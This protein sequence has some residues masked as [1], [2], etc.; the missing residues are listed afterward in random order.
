[1]TLASKMKEKIWRFLEST[2]SN[3]SFIA[4]S[5]NRSFI[6]GSKISKGIFDHRESIAGILRSLFDSQP[7]IF[8]CCHFIFYCFY[9]KLRPWCKRLSNSFERIKKYRKDFWSLINWNQCYLVS[10]HPKCFT[11]IVF[12][13]L[14]TFS[15]SLLKLIFFDI[16][17]NKH[18]PIIEWLKK[19]RSA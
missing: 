3:V 10:Y 6:S 12:V 7:L 9:N 14:K 2:E 11:R 19:K 15:E 16:H 8:N 5:G 18:W 13:H 1:M 17:L 4:I